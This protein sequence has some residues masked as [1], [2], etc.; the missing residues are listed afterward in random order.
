MKFLR[1]RDRRALLIC[2][3]TITLSAAYRYAVLP[4][5][6]AITR[7]SDEL[8]AERELLT[9]ELSLVAD[10]PALT[11][12]VKSAGA[13]VLG[14][15]PRLFA[16]ER[17]ANLSAAEIQAYLQ[18]VA[19]LAHLNIQQLDVEPHDTAASHELSGITIRVRGQADYEGLLTFTRAI[20]EG[21]KLFSVRD[22]LVQ[23]PPGSANSSTPYQVLDYTM[24]VTAWT[25]RAG[26]E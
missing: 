2:A 3:A 12:A 22:V 25:F 21:P 15:A 7:A 19:A 8:V 9:R 5:L 24:R 11:E 23:Q 14:I 4:Y 26:A 17:D 1:P 6:Q 16:A 10:V 20:E 13:M 18:E